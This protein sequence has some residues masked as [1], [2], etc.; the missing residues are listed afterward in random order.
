LYVWGSD[1]IYQ[2]DGVGAMKNVGDKIRPV[3]Y[4]RDNTSD[5]CAGVFEDHVMFSSVSGGSYEIHD[6]A[7]A[8]G[9]VKHSLPGSQ[10]EV[11]SFTRKDTPLYAAIAD[12][13]DLFTMFTGTG[14]AMGKD[15]ATGY[16]AGWYT[17]WFLPNSGMLARL[18]RALVQGVIGSSATLFFNLF[19]DW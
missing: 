14:S 15:D 2:C 4:N 5:V 19:K 8:G 3:F 1:G 11:S 12:G 17:P 13:D 10:D 9:I 16:S 7:P 6:V 18:Q